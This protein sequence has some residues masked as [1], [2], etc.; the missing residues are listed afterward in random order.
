MLKGFQKLIWGFQ[1]FEK[2]VHVGFLSQDFGMFPQRLNEI[3]F[4]LRIGSTLT[5]NWVTL[6]NI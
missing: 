2:A 4:H 3:L 6:Y 1:I 5:K